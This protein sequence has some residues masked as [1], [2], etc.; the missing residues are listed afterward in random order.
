MCSGRFRFTREKANSRM[1]AMMQPARFSS[2]SCRDDPSITAPPPPCM[3]QFRRLPQ[4]GASPAIPHQKEVV[5]GGSPPQDQN[6][7]VRC[8][9]PHHGGERD[10]YCR[11]SPHTDHGHRSSLPQTTLPHHSSGQQTHEKSRNHISPV[12]II[13]LP[14]PTLPYTLQPH[15]TVARLVSH[16]PN[17]P[18]FLPPTMPAT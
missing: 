7:A 4:L 5:P 17:P 13:M 3:L 12:V 14:H 6:G 15:S 9:R 11:S 1:I 16:H 2:S 8:T 18:S 10:R